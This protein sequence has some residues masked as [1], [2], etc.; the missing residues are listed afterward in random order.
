MNPTHV[1]YE[2]HTWVPPLRS[3]HFVP[4]SPTRAL[5]APAS[6]AL[7][8]R[9]REGQRRAALRAGRSTGAPRAAAK[10]EIG[11][12]PHTWDP[13]PSLHFVPGIPGTA[14]AYT[15][16]GAGRAGPERSRARSLL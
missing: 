7:R 1:A 12:E 16:E 13:L 3:G 15:I 2:P 9:P 5:Y 8:A 11:Y 10:R 6:H 4:G 14:S